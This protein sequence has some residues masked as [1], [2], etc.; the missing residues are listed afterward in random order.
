[1]LKISI[2]RLIGLPTNDVKIPGLLGY[3]WLVYDDTDTADT[4]DTGGR[5][6]R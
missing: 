5:S 6:R 4:T 3:F 2:I 1:M